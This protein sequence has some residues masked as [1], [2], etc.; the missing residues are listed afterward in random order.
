[1]SDGHC[2]MV[3]SP[4]AHGN[5]TDIRL[6]HGS[7]V[8]TVK[9]V[10]PQSDIYKYHWIIFQ[11]VHKVCP[12]VHTRK[13]MHAHIHQPFPKPPISFVA[14]GPNSCKMETL[15]RG[16]H[17]QCSVHPILPTSTTG[18]II[19]R[20][21]NTPARDQCTAAMATTLD[22]CVSRHCRDI[23]ILP[24][25]ITIHFSGEQPN[26]LPILNE[27]F[28]STKALHGTCSVFSG[29][30]HQ[31]HSCTVSSSASTQ[32]TEGSR[33]HRVNAPLKPPKVHHCA[34]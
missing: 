2:P 26:S 1:M 30:H 9:T 10:M 23:L 6:I 21:S 3:S 5:S 12:T 15:V 16:L 20:S 19:I 7:Y 27:T 25:N 33:L 29:M 24:L 32:G 18:T 8:S 11:Q 13:R 31:L 22:A 14:H 28:H 34:H 4:L 17:N